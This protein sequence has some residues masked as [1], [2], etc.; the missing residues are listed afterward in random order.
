M[1]GG[2]NNFG[3]NLGGGFPASLNNNFAA[4]PGPKIIDSF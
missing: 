1:G 3:T 4:G 2:L